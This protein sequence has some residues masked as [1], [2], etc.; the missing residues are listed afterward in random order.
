[1]AWEKEEEEM[2]RGGF[3]VMG[4]RRPIANPDD[5]SRGL[6][7]HLNRRVSTDLL[8]IALQLWEM[9]TMERLIV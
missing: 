9:E 6:I 1:M 7:K 5:V 2:K 3:D 8:K 4:R